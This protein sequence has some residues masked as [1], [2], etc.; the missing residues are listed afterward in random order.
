MEWLQTWSPSTSKKEQGKSQSTSTTNTGEWVHSS[1]K[2]VWMIAIL[3]S[4]LQLYNRRKKCLKDAEMAL[5]EQIDA[6]YMSEE[7]THESEDGIV[8]YKHSPSFRSSSKCV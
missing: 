2:C 5:W 8:V 1:T 3:L 4:F 7:S 6:S